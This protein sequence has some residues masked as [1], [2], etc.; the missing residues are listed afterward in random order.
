MFATSSKRG[1]WPRE[2]APCLEGTAGRAVAVS[3]LLR[4]A[5]G[6]DGRQGPLAGAV[7]ALSPPQDSTAAALKQGLTS[8]A[9]G[10]VAATVSKTATA[11]LERVKLVIQV[12]RNAA[13]RRS[14]SGAHTRARAADPQTS[15]NHKLVKAGKI[16]PYKGI[17]A[18]FVR[19]YAEQ[20]VA[21][22]WL[23]NGA[24]VLRYAPTQAINLGVKDWCNGLFPVYNR[25]TQWVRFVGAKVLSGGIAGGIGL[26]FVYPLDMARTRLA[27]DVVEDGGQKQFKGLVDCVRKT[28]AGPEGVRGLYRGYV[29]SVAGIIPYRAVQFGFFDT[30]RTYNP[31]TAENSLRGAASNF[32]VA[33][34]AAILS[35]Y[36]SYPIDTVR[37]ALQM[38]AERPAHKRSFNGGVDCFKQ[39]WRSGGVRAFYDGALANAARTMGSAMVLVM[40]AQGLNLIKSREA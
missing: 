20:G 17:G 15:K 37:R 9:L 30:V 7:V 39:T 14:V 1:A 8:F 13:M 31:W 29:I 5:A 24:N 3:P 22:F 10:G 27:A 25:D 28:A 2:V 26:T 23:G 40:Y 11:P 16:P 34:T 6:V 35:A 21:S 38:E 33:Q 12:R 4:V 19:L 18:T 32:L 36:A